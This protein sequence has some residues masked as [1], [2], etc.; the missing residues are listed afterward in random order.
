MSLI[1]LAAVTG[2]SILCALAPPILARLIGWA[3]RWR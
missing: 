2:A 1:E 3:A